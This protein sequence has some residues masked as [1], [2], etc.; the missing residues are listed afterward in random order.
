MV[1]DDW[2]DELVLVA[3]ETAPGRARAFVRN[4][5]SSHDWLEQVENTL[6]LTTELTTNALVHAGTAIR[7]QINGA[8]D[9]LT[10]L[11]ADQTPGRLAGV[12]RAPDELHEGGRGLYLVDTLSSSWGTEHTKQ[13]KAVW[14]KFLRGAA[15]APFSWAVAADPEE[16]LER[17][18]AADPAWL[19]AAGSATLEK[20]NLSEFVGELLWRT[21]ETLGAAAGVVVIDDEESGQPRLAG[22][23]GLAADLAAELVDRVAATRGHPPLPHAPGG[24]T[25]GL[26]M[27]GL[28][29]HRRRGAEPRRERA[30][31]DGAVGSARQAVVPW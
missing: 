1:S 30:G 20:L 22:Q 4:V 26:L 23:H 6:L 18:L 17:V 19:T 15:E 8:G 12:P 14:F 11:V 7:V 13:G 9:T 24:D 10:V 5:L 27:Q 16:E 2:T 29:R 3:D 31:L 28:A 21:M 25:S